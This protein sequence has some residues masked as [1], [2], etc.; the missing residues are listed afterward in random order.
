MHLPPI[1]PAGDA[2]LPLIALAEGWGGA[3][4]SAQLCN[5]G[6]NNRVYRILTRDG[7][8]AGKFYGSGPDERDRLGHEFDGLSFLKA[9]GIGSALPSPLTDDRREHCAL[10]EWVEGAKAADHGPADIAAVVDLLTAIHDARN[11]PA[12]IRLPLAT[13]AVLCPT[14]LFEQIERRLAR[15]SAVATSEPAL[16]DF[17][18]SELRPEIERRMRALDDSDADAELPPGSRTLSPSDFGFHNAL[19]R[20]DGALTF[21]D[22]EYFGWDDPVKL[23]SDFLWHPAMELSIG[24]REAFA[25]GV[26]HLYGREASFS[27][28]FAACFPLYGIRWILIILNEFVPQL[29]A[30]RA[31]AG[32]GADWEAAKREQ[33]A[34]ARTM[35]ETLLPYRE[36]LFHK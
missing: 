32:K 23:C 2:P 6:G 20:P 4:V 16:A 9:A 17:I 5:G 33:L 26:T 3:V 10:Y 19:R 22:F 15:L 13:E 34:K 30:R 24:E 36:G 12:A 31:F 8:V 21:I 1:E 11:A 18:A 28:R 35:L 14:N 29:W 25:H 27:A 7:L